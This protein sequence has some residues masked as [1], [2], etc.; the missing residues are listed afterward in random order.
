MIPRFNPRQGEHLGSLIQ[1]PSIISL[2]KCFYVIEKEKN[3]NLTD[4]PI[5][6]AK[7]FAQIM[8]FVRGSTLSDQL[9]KKL[10][11]LNELLDIFLDIANGVGHLSAQ[12]IIHG[13]I[14]Q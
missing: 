12:R 11:N 3:I 7:Y 14:Y 13:D 9:T 4:T 8:P 10:L 2:L 1:H 5:E 6:N